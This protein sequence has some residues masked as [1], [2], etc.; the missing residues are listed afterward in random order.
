MLR[1][2]LFLLPALLSLAPCRAETEVE[3]ANQEKI[4]LVG[5]PLDPKSLDHQLVTGVTDYN[6]IRSLMEGLVADDESS[7]TAC[8]PGAASSWEHNADLTE[9]IFHLRPEGKWSD[10]APLTSADFLCAYERILHPEVD[11]PF[12]EM[13]FFLKNAE[14]FHKGEL[15]DFKEV[16]VAAPDD[17]TLKLTLR[18]PVPFLPLLVR[19]PAWFPLPRH[20]ALKCGPLDSRS[21]W[22]SSA[23]H[24]TGNGPFM[25]K[26][27]AAGVQVEVGRNPRYWNAAKVKL[28]GIR[29]L[30]MGDS[31]KQSRAFLAGKLHL[32]W[33]LLPR[34][35]DQFRAN[36]PQYVRQ[37]PY[38]CTDLIRVNT[39]R[40]KLDN[41]KLRQALSL[42]IDRQSL[43]DDIWNG[44]R[45]AGTITPE[46]GD[47]DPEPLTG[48]DPDRAKVLLTEAGYPGGAGLPPFKLL[49]TST[50]PHD[51]L[52]AITGM[53]RKTLGIEVELRTEEFADYVAAQQ[54]LD[55][56]LALAAWIG[57][58]MDPSAF[59]GMWMKDS[60]NNNTGWSSA[61]YEK[62]L[63]EAASQAD[64]AQRLATFKKAGRLFME[65]LPV[66]PVCYRGRNYLQRPE[67][68][69][70]HPLLLDNHP[71]QA[72]S[73]E[74]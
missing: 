45:P 11:A 5:T 56:D 19:H 33:Q 72:V 48:F 15:M 25:P 13:L 59:L 9:W 32:T 41:P 70:W 62:L 52:E 1:R 23:D 46:Q 55:Y 57:D 2:A 60:G 14:R 36:N 74:P 22:W 43:C 63:S 49:V 34:M 69:G 20:V 30:T 3:K 54:K 58:Y 16:G 21:N 29:F 53:W 37:E 26:S 47:Y 10:G 51:S 12:C 7:D 18:E 24:Y 61:E 31:G 44:N 66:L 39:T 27:S 67:V 65:E 6:I 71:W 73:L 64:P 40:P 4:L 8:P 68:K 42:A 50:M 35:V 17:Y 38:F 28:N